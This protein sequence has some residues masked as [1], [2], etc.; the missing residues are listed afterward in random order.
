MPRK[1]TI[2]TYV[3]HE[4]WCCDR[5]DN[6][7]TEHAAIEHDPQIFQQLLS[8]LH[9]MLAPDW[10]TWLRGSQVSP[11]VNAT[12][13]TAELRHDI[14]VRVIG[15]LQDCI[16]LSTKEQFWQCRGREI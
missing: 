12:P 16:I 9:A 4:C 11:G 15:C 13:A 6:T 3:L 8:V 14:S 5:D 2:L 10:A 7:G 1:A